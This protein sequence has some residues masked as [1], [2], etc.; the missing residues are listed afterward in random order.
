MKLLLVAEK[1]VILVVYDRLSKIAYFVV[2]IEGILVKGLVR[3]FRN[4]MQK[5]HGLLESIILDR[6]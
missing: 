4:N 6:R 2:T 1:D 5:L 3:L